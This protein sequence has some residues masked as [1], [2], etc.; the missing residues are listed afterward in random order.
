MSII[1]PRGDVSLVTSDTRFLLVETHGNRW[2]RL[3]PLGVDRAL[4][5][6][7]TGRGSSILHAVGSHQ[8]CKGC[9]VISGL[10]SILLSL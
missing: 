3:R 10:V 4:S 5:S 8:G 7:V 9:V 1:L 6:V 2:I